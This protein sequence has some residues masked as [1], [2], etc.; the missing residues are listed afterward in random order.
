MLSKIYLGLG[1]GLL[2]GYLSWSVMGMEWESRKDSVPKVQARRSSSSSGRRGYG[3]YGGGYG[4][5]K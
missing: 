1:A 3:F 2:F 4:Y 5:G